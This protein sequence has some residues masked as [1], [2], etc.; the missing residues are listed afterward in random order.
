MASPNDFAAPKMNPEVQARLMAFQARRQQLQSQSSASTG[1]LRSQEQQQQPQEQQQQENPPQI[2]PVED[3]SRRTSFR[4]QK[5]EEQQQTGSFN[6]NLKRNNSYNKSATASNAF[7]INKSVEYITKVKMEQ[8]NRLRPSSAMEINSPSLSIS[9]STDGIIN[10][11][12][13]SSASSSPSPISTTPLSPKLSLSQRRGMKLDF[14]SL[15]S[16]SVLQHES[17]KTN[18]NQ[19]SDS[20]KAMSIQE[21]MKKNTLPDRR[22]RPNLKMSQNL[23]L[24]QQQQ[25]PQQSTKP[26]G[27]FASYSKYID[28]K[29]GSLNF[30]GKASLHSKGIDFSNGSSFRISM[31]DL[32]FLDELGRGNYGVVSKVLHKPT[33]IIMAMKEVRLELDDAKFAQIL[34]ELEVLHSCKSDCIVEFY[35]AFFIEGA[36]YMCMEYMMGG[37]IDKIYG[38]GINEIGLCYITKRV[39]TGLRELKDEHNVIHRDVKPTNMLVNDIGIVKLCDFGVSGNLVAS[40][41]RTNIGCQSYMAPERI[42]HSNFGDDTY[43]VQSDI[44]SLGLSILEISKGCYPYPPETF[45][46]VF[47]QLSAIVDG[48]PPELPDNFSDDAKDFVAQC[49]NKNPQNRPTYSQLIQH[50]W[51]QNC[52]E[53]NGRSQLAKLVTEKSNLN[54]KTTKSIPALHRGGNPNTF[55]V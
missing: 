34:M 41:A 32:E 36:V 4:L 13:T 12:N 3:L 19:L 7:H 15:S 2:Q 5:S 21:K 14:N 44:W 31:D 1:D 20:V 53:E 26:S 25:L 23:P 50:K 37:S 17:S 33:G 55:P 48:E 40:L 52:N 49:L 47:S 22:R 18:V 29:S 24:K 8:A 42:K 35:G 51:I 9:T 10:S 45:N 27:M 46:N 30:S 43:S 11:N 6:D 54:Q 39:V 28:V 38:D 16:P